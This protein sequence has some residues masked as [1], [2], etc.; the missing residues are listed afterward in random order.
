MGTVANMVAMAVTAGATA[1]GKEVASSAV[2]D[3]YTALKAFLT[4]RIKRADMLVEDIESN[5]SSDLEQQLLE[6]N[7][8]QSEHA[9]DPEIADLAKQLIAAVES[10]KT[11]PRAQ[12]LFDFEKLRLAGD[13]DFSDIETSGGVVRGDDVEIGGNLTAKGIRQ[14]N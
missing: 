8:E 12:A 13:A 6:K 1:I 14:K 2:K 3:A 10:L 9:N 11:D 5:P 4:S 7:V